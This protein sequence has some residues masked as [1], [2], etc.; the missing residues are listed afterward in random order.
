MGIEV[1]VLMN[2]LKNVS[3]IMCFVGGV[4]AAFLQAIVGNNPCYF[5]YALTNYTSAPVILE[6]PEQKGELPHNH[7]SSIFTFRLVFGIPLDGLEG[8]ILQETV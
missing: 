2:I 1:H 6:V 7:V 8:S 5:N 4:V 3:N